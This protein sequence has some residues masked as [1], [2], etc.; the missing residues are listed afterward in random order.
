M[1]LFDF[2]ACV[3]IVGRGLD[4]DQGRMTGSVI[5]AVVAAAAGMVLKQ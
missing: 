4:P 2:C 1:P 3:V 5:I